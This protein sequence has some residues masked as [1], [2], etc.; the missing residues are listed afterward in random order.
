MKKIVFMLIAASSLI[1][2]QTYTTTAAANHLGEQA[3]VCRIVLGGYYARSSKGQPTFINLDGAY[4]SQ[5]F[6]IVIWGDD[7]YKFKSPER[8]YNNKKLCATGIIG[9]HN[10]IPQIVVSNMSQL[11]RGDVNE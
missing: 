11:H 6:T 1:L 5:K 8:R 3:T 10:G 7:R 9:S 2:A 4:P